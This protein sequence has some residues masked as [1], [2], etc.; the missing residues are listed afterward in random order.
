MTSPEKVISEQQTAS[1]ATATQSE[2]SDYAE[3]FSKAMSQ[4]NA[5]SLRQTQGLLDIAARAAEKFHSINRSATVINKDV[6]AGFIDEIKSVA[7][8]VSQINQQT[9]ENLSP[10]PAPNPES[11]LAA[12]EQAL[13]DAVRNSVSNQQQLNVIGAAILTQ[14]AALLLS[15][16][17]KES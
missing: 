16:G 10:E 13:S 2:I 14:S 11:F 17:E 3:I 6:L 5:V 9:P 15:T 8:D 7:A 12:V 4:L 1:A